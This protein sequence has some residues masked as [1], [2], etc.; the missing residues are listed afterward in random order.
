MLDDTLVNERSS[1]AL[2]REL[3]DLRYRITRLQEDLEYVSKGPRTTAKDEER[4][5][6]ER[7]LVRLMHEEVPELEKKVEEREGRREREKREW[8]RDR[9]R[10]NERFGRFGGDDNGR[11]SP[12]SRYRD[13][14]E[15][16]YSRSASRYDR[17]DRDNDRDRSYRDGDRDR[18][19]DSDGERERERGLSTATRTP[20]PPPPPPA[21]SASQ[22]P[23][24]PPPARSPAPSMKN[25]TP[26]ER[27]AFIRAEAQRRL[28]ARKQALGVVAPSSVSVAS[29]TLD[30]TIEDRLAQEKKEAE[31]KVREAERQA[32]ER[33]KQRKDKLEAEKALKGGTTSSPTPTTTAP[34]PAPAPAP[35]P[36]SVKIAPPPPKPRAPAPPPPRKG[37]TSRTVAP[38]IAPRVPP[39]PTPV[40]RAPSPPPALAPAVPEEDPED[41]A[42]R[43]REEALRKKREERAALLRKLEEEEEEEARKTEAAYQERRNQFLTSKASPTVSTTSTVSSLPAPPPPAPPVSAPVQE[44]E[45]PQEVA[46]PPPPPPPPVP[47]TSAPVSDKP[48]NNP[49]S[50]LMKEGGGSASTAPPITTAN[51]SSNPFFRTQT[52]PPVVP[53][54]PKSPGIPPPVKTTYHT[55][56]KDSD[57]DWDDVMENEENDSSDEEL[58]TRDTRMGLAQQLFG[59]LLP[60]RPQSA[61]PVPASG[62]PVSA[63]APAPPPP[64][65]PPSAPPAPA[66]PSVQIAPLAPTGDR[67]ALLGAIQG[68]ARLRKTATND[69]SGAATSGRVIGDIAPPAHINTVTRPPSPPTVPPPASFTASPSPAEL[70]PASPMGQNTSFGHGKKESVDWYNALA[71]DV[72]TREVDHLPVTM[73]EGE[74]E[75]GASAVPA[76]QVSEHAADN[77]SELMA[78]VDL[79][80]GAYTCHL[81][82]MITALM[83]DLFCSEFRARSLYPYQGQRAED[84]GACVAVVMYGSAT[85]DFECKRTDF[86]I[87]VVIVAHPSKSGGDWWYGTT[88]KD[89]KVGFFPQTYVQK[90]EQGALLLIVP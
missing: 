28:E 33:E 24:P 3:E 77:E 29:P 54:P 12:A 90:V 52:A 6:L 26:A 53:P 14:E 44:E 85:Q 71:A 72:N 19:R 40:I 25:M 9:D 76:I 65:P 13:E 78:D 30:T 68:G 55:A 4:R 51:A 84:L 46:P 37:I 43:L 45:P 63:A 86:D 62:S 88:V 31:E 59:N 48:S 5:R 80:S 60:S 7:E 79:S 20:P 34:P 49:F 17:D 61:G 1:D 74:E 21:T 89:G 64:P 75:A 16:P 41:A 57:D 18:N 69:R 56:P 22:P 38:S 47:P 73:E 8:A 70:P 2:D 23:P 15:R 81:C 58:G 36:T 32:E 10:R 27:Q 11:Y 67:S 50:R 82:A 35:V 42:L 87:N 83:S 66:A 39:A